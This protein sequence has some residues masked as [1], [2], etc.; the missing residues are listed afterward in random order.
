MNRP[1]SNIKTRTINIDGVI[2]ELLNT[3]EVR[4][5]NTWNDWHGEDVLN[6][7]L[8]QD[9]EVYNGSIELMYKLNFIDKDRW[10]RE[11]DNGYN[12]YNRIAHK[13]RNIK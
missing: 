1:G 9:L 6:E 13:P 4:L 10:N 3:L 8:N 12:L 7:Y 2:Q 5:N 11:T